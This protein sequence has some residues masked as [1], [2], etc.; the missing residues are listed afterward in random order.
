MQASHAC[1]PG[2]TPGVRICGLL[3]CCL[4]TTT[5]R[6]AIAQALDMALALDLN[7]LISLHLGLSPSPSLSSPCHHDAYS[8][9]DSNPQAPPQEGGALSIRPHEQLLAGSGPHA[10]VRT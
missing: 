10:R 1:D 4:T 5:S 2:S 3:R 9:R 8:R 7:V 6:Q